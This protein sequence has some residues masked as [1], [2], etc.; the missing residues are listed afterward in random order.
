MFLVECSLSETMTPW[1]EQAPPEWA[2]VDVLCSLVSGQRRLIWGEGNP[3]ADIAIVLDNPGARE[4]HQG[5]PY[6][7]GTRQTLRQALAAAD[8]S[9]EDIYLTFLYKCRPRGKYDPKIAQRTFVPLLEAQII[10]GGYRLLI[11]L[12]N[13]VV[14]ALLD[15]KADVKQLRGHNQQWLERPVSISYHPLAARRR[16]NLFPLLIEDLRLAWMQRNADG[17]W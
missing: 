17:Q 10:K 14:K 1:P 3:Q 6:V 13:T 2:D 8:I 11:F 5:L 4:N 12:G 15:E 7:C 16:P 9:G